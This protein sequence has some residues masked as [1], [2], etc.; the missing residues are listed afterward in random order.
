MSDLPQ[1]LSPKKDILNFSCDTDIFLSVTL[2]TLM[3]ISN[4]LSIC[5]SLLLGRLTEKSA[6]TSMRTERMRSFWFS[7]HHLT[8]FFL[9]AFLH[10]EIP[11]N[12]CITFTHLKSRWA[13]YRSDSNNNTCFR[14]EAQLHSNSSIWFGTEGPGYRGSEHFGVCSK[15]QQE[16]PHSAWGQNG[17]GDASYGGK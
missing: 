16:Q 2:S 3:G 8:F 17:R 10:S 1:E 12:L 13:L 9:K 11:H 5:L 4:A 7:V 15:N 14:H 6:L